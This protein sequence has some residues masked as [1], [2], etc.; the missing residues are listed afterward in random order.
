VFGSSW[1]GT[2]ISGGGPISRTSNSRATTPTTV[3]G[4]PDNVMLVPRTFGSLFRRCVQK[5]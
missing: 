1:N 5:L 4:L 3:Y 2:Q